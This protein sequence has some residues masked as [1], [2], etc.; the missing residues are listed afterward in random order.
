MLAVPDGEGEAA[1]DA[2]K[3]AIAELPAFQRPSVFHLVEADLPR[4]ATRKVQR[5][6]VK[7]VLERIHAASSVRR[8][9]R[10]GNEG[11]VVGAV[12]AVAGIARD[13]VNANTNLV[14]SLAFDSLMWVELAAAL[15]GMGLGHF[16]VVDLARCE[17]IA[18]LVEFVGQNPARLP[19]QEMTDAPDQVQIPAFIAGPVRRAL[20]SGQ[21]Q[22]NGVVLD[23][24]VEGEAH[25]PQNRQTIVVCNHT[26]HLDMGLVKFALGGYGEQMAALAAQDYFFE[27]NKWKVA[28]FT[29]LTHLE[30]IDRRSGFR[31]SLQQAKEVLDRGHVVLIFPEGTRRTDGTLGE[32]KP[33][34]GKLCLDTQVDILPLH[35]DGAFRSLP[36]GAAFPKARGINIR[37]GPPLCMSDLL[38]LSEGQKASDAA[39]TVANLAQRAVESLRDGDFFDIS[40]IEQLEAASSTSRGI[41]GVMKDLEGKFDPS[42]V[43]KPI[44]WYFALGGKEGPRWT[45][46]V[47]EEQ[48]RMQPGRPQN[49]SADCVVKTSTELFSKLVC[50]SYVPSPAEFMSGAIK[51]NEIPLLIEFSRVFNLTDVQA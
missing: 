14:E 8:T 29:Y 42:R 49:G 23:T 40:A 6:E 30:P 1:R 18:E 10:G 5:K 39:R 3:D 48:C 47:D 22:L 12:V 16:E 35:I 25:I 32:F 15:D 27:G 2:I 9:V 7:K 45:V 37:I 34:V 21:R 24:Q 51:T 19:D 38:R 36:K 41:E 26:S 43:E 28:Y 46:S 33:L 44:S 17:T 31:T 20:L 50:E 13:K 4:T 11:P